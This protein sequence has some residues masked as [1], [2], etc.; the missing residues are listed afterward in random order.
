M[1]KAIP[2]IG[3]ILAIIL[4]GCSTPGSTP[5]SRSGGDK[6]SGSAVTSPPPRPEPDWINS[7]S[8]N[9][10][11][12]EYITKKAD[13][14]NA[15]QARQEARD[16][17]IALFTYV[18]P[19]SSGNTTK[20]SSAALIA[21]AAPEIVS[22]ITIV[23]EWQ[24]PDTKTYYALAAMQ[25]KHGESYMKTKIPQLDQETQKTI[26]TAA[27]KNIDPLRRTGFLAK[28]LRAQKQRQYLQQSM[29]TVDVTGRGIKPVW[30]VVR[31]E[32]DLEEQLKQLK[33]QPVGASDDK[34]ESQLMANLLT[35]GLKTAGLTPADGNHADYLLK[36]KLSI[37]PKRLPNNWVS[38]QGVLHIEL[39]EKIAGLGRG[40]KRWEIE[41][42]GLD[43][44]AAARRVTEKAEFT[45]KKEMRTVLLEIA[46]N[47]P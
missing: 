33:I 30:D 29:R 44:E 42:P 31:I 25:R 23:D 46:I 13:A 3:V 5:S 7:E 28:A 22:S 2:V 47:Q 17:I 36:G 21:T 11:R 14:N 9:Y 40:E 16:K 12:I 32:A 19:N 26:D 4:S 45:L 24:S 39:A 10:G 35:G 41:M 27:I 38:G 37:D 18:D 15:E 6:A 34:S 1:I 20:T 8:A 43:E